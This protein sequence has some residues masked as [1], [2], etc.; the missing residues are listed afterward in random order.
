[1]SHSQILLVSWLICL[2]KIFLKIWNKVQSN[3]FCVKIPQT[4]VAF[5][6]AHFRWN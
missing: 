4:C 3:L 6:N 1:M 5:E 2:L